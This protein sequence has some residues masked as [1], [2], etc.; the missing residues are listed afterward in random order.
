MVYNFYQNSTGK[1]PVISSRIAYAACDR[2]ERISDSDASSHQTAA[3][4]RSEVFFGCKAVKLGLDGTYVEEEMNK[5]KW[6]LIFTWLYYP[7]YFVLD[8]MSFN[9][10]L[11][12]L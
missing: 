11:A 5:S 8:F 2:L 7:E 1:G 3:Q 6:N 12:A 4:F 10:Y 9:S